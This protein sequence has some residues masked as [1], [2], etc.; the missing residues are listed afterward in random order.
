MM[1][2]AGHTSG[3]DLLTEWLATLQRAGG[4]STPRP[5]QA[6]LG[7]AL[8]ERYAEHHRHYH[9][10][11]HLIAV[12]S[13]VDELAS[14]A[15]SPDLVRLAA[16]YHDAVYDPRRT[17]NEAR[18][19]DLA[20]AELGLAGLPPDTVARVAALVALTAGHEAP[21]DDGN[22]AVLCDAD[23]AVLARPGPDYD[24][25]AAVVRRE[26]GH[27]DDAAW[28]LGRAAVLQGLAGRPQLFRTT[29][30][31]FWEPAARANLSR[32]LAALGAPSGGATRPR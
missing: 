31:R 2:P 15:D 23:L 6:A 21:A 20:E 19:A 3:V 17:D 7:S 32:E 29:P 24:R 22:A 14:Y 5:R 11:E 25:Y 4:C 26:Y 10:V 30:A 27:L 28:R 12:L 9:N 18:S 8:I 1:P 13:T 16:W